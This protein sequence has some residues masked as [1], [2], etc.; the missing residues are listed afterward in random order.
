MS[1]ILPQGYIRWN[2]ITYVFDASNLITG[3]AGD[4]GIPG[5]PG[6]PGVDG[7]TGPVGAAGLQ[8][9]PGPTGPVGD[10]GATGAT[11]PTGPTGAT[12]LIAGP[13]GATGATGATGPTGATGATGPTGATGA[14]GAS[15]SFSGSADFV[16]DSSYG[17]IKLHPAGQ[18][19]PQQPISTSFPT[20]RGEVAT[21]YSIQENLTTTASPRISVSTVVANGNEI[22]ASGSPVSPATFLDPPIYR[23]DILTGTFLGFSVATGINWSTCEIYYCRLKYTDVIVLSGI[24]NASV[25]HA[26]Y[27]RL[28]TNTFVDLSSSLNGSD[29]GRAYAI[30]VSEKEFALAAWTA[31]LTAFDYTSG[32]IHIFGHPS[33]GSSTITEIQSLSIN[34]S[35]DTTNIFDVQSSSTG[36]LIYHAFGYWWVVGNPDGGELGKIFVFNETTGAA[37]AAISNGSLAVLTGGAT[38]SL[39]DNGKHLLATSI[40]GG[41]TASA[42][43]TT[44]IDWQTFATTSFSNNIAPFSS[45]NPTWQVWDGLYYYDSGSGA[46]D[47][48]P[49]YGEPGNLSGTRRELGRHGSGGNKIAMSTVTNPVDGISLLSYNSTSI[50]IFYAPKKLSLDAIK[51]NGDVILGAAQFVT[52]SV[53]STP[54]NITVSDNIL[55]VDT[56]SAKTINL[57]ASPL[58]GRKLIISDSTGNAN[59]NNITINGN[60]NNIGAVSSITIN[61]QWKGRTLLFNGTVWI[62]L[63]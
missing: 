41:V 11:G 23:Y 46:V 40:D 19:R 22:L 20:P 63:A 18:R 5:I 8:G 61:I 28:D 55:L 58:A 33:A 16:P 47:Y 2:G 31:N 52:T 26:G 13:T 7:A 29:P 10:T 12:S 37:V 27:I 35:I 48:V 4:P 59:T 14:T 42:G 39:I 56:S 54:Y 36:L 62:I 25:Y 60:G 43:H 6:N 17:L 34:N 45:Y 30:Y 44:L 38:K 15:G 3:P 32:I 53:T 50:Q 21:V 57:P 1:S 51:I 49:L 9:I 24:D